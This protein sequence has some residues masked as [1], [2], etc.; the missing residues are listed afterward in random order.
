[1]I[2]KTRAA[3]ALATSFA[4][5]PPA[6]AD[7]WYDGGDLNDKDNVAWQEAEA[8]NRL[9]SAANTVAALWT[10]E[11]LVAEI[12]A[13]ITTMD[14]MK[15]YATQLMTCIDTATEK[16]FGGVRVNYSDMALGCVMLME[17]TKP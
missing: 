14:A 8:N 13:E 7:E 12:H 9:A 5:M 16:G 15:P 3:F 17:W 6:F 10:N 2:M 11:Y 1:M 4:I